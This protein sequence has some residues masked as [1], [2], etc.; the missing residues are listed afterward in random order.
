MLAFG[1]FSLIGG[2]IVYGL[3]SGGAIC[4]SAADPCNEELSASYG[5]FGAGAV[6]TSGGIAML[7][8]GSVY[9]F[10]AVFGQLDPPP[11]RA[12]ALT[13]A[14]PAGSYSA[15]SGLRLSF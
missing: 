6:M 4:G 7:I 2:G 14:A 13:P 11:G 1:I 3:S 5:L 10:K 8:A 9:R 12:F 15:T